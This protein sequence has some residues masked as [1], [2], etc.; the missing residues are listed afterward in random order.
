MSSPQHFH[1]ETKLLMFA[2]PLVPK[3]DDFAPGKQL[4]KLVHDLV[5]AEK[6]LR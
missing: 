3:D 6:S 4:S 1:E 2:K 5:L